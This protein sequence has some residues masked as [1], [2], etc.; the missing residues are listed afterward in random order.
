MSYPHPQTISRLGI[1][2]GLSSNYIV[3]ITQDKDGF[4]WFASEEGLNKFDGTRFINYYKHTNSISAN[5]LNCIY[6]DPVEPVIWIATQRGGLNAYNY[7][8]NTLRVYQHDDAMPHSIITNDV[9]A[10]APSAD[11]N[12]WI[13]TYHRGFEYFDRESET[14]THFNMSSFP[15]LQSE[16]IWSILDDHNGNL[17]IGHVRRRHKRLR[18]GQKNRSLQQRK[19]KPLAQFRYDRLSGLEKRYMDR[20]LL[21]RNKFLQ[22]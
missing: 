19:R 11:G 14:F 3:N 20:C 16:N 2:Q 17:Y 5:E 22:L 1:E 12:L 6:A 7:E 10:I 9:T 21:R 4:M 13:S 8:K 18:P 15:E